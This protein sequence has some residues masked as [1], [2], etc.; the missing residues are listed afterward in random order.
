M[1]DK[2][3]KGVRKLM[4]EVS[5]A[6][7]TCRMIESGGYKRPPGFTAQQLVDQLPDE[8]RL[9]ALRMARAAL[10]YVSECFSAARAVQ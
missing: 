1:T 9:G 5:E 4:A 3:A 7:L 10:T 8:Q 6:E 2:M